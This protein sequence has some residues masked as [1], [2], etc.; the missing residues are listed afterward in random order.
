MREGLGTDG[1]FRLLLA[2]A[3]SFTLAL[4]GGS[5]MS[6]SGVGETCTLAF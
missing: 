3:F 1:A 5:L 4:G 2:L 6:T